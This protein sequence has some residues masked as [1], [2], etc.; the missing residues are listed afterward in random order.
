MTVEP[1]RYVEATLARGRDT[2]ESQQIWF[3]KGASG[4]GELEV[5]AVKMSHHGSRANLSK[6][7]LSLVDAEHFLISTNG[8]I[9][10]HPDVPAI[11]AVIAGSR[12]SPTLW[13]NYRIDLTKDWEARSNLP[14]AKFRTR[15]PDDGMA[16]ITIEL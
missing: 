13:F 12:R 6:R 5:D 15:Y 9:H 10:D 3:W 14:D 11:E 4:R 1:Q 8:A 2:G 16:G 7:F